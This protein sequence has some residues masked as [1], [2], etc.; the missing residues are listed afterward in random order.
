[1]TSMDYFLEKKKEF[2]KKKIKKLSSSEYK[3]QRELIEKEN[4]EKD[5]INKRRSEILKIYERY[6]YIELTAY[7]RWIGNRYSKEQL[8][9]TKYYAK[10]LSTINSN[11][12]I[13]SVLYVI[14]RIDEGEDIPDDV[15]EHIDQIVKLLKNYDI[16]TLGD[17]VNT[18][19]SKW[20][21][22]NNDMIK[23]NITDNFGSLID[24]HEIMEEIA[25]LTYPIKININANMEMA[26]LAL[27]DKY[28][29]ERL[30]NIIRDK[31]IQEKR[32][33]YN[34]IYHGSVPE[35]PP[36]PRPKFMYSGKRRKSKSRK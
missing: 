11:S 18:S 36:A 25:S 20:D 19:R 6:P 22:M 9:E 27:R 16:K 35:A 29:R 14:R 32:E 5:K 23:N 34:D 28:P 15:K 33:I 8:N 26:K 17:V 13:K 7:P 21:K 3:L 10:L 24:F 31:S 1:M 30:I 2:D 4:K 12:S